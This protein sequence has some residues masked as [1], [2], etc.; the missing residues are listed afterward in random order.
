MGSLTIKNLPEHLRARIKAQ[1]QRNHRSP[2]EEA[3]RLIE[4]GLTGGA[5]QC[6]VPPAVKLL[7]AHIATF[8]EIEAHIADGRE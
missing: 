2:A 5:A 1:A 7:G 8:E 3:V 6:I 4:A